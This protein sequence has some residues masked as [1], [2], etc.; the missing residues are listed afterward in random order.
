MGNILWKYEQTSP[1]GVLYKWSAT[2]F[3]QEQDYQR[4]REV[5][6]EVAHNKTT[7]ECVKCAVKLPTSTKSFA[8]FC[9][10]VEQY[11]TDD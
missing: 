2:G 5:C 8:A 9:M 4:V 11:K 10:V 1:Q 3:F 7:Y 6:S